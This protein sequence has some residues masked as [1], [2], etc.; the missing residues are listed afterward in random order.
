MEVAGIRSDKDRTARSCLL[1][2]LL[3]LKLR[4]MK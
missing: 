1:F 2:I 4:S 3:I